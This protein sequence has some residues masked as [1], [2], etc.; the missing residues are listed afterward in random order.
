MLR[1]PINR[2][3]A[4]GAQRH[5][6]A[7]VNTTLLNKATAAG[8]GGGGAI[9]GMGNTRAAVQSSAA[10]TMNHSLARL[11]EVRHRLEDYVVWT[12]RA[13]DN[14]VGAEDDAFCGCSFVEFASEITGAANMG[15]L[16][17]QIDSLIVSENGIIEILEELM[18]KCELAFAATA[19]VP[20]LQPHRLPTS[21]SAEDFAASMMNHTAPMRDSKVRE[22]R[23]LLS[24]DRRQEIVLV[25]AKLIANIRK[26][27]QWKREDLENLA[28]LFD[29]FCTAQD[30]HHRLL[31]S[32]EE[33]LRNGWS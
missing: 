23:L 18:L 3:A 16:N 13:W 9:G 17:E 4:G 30:Q 15:I 20:Q 19:S 11:Q 29:S 22:L 32:I 28:A 14:L 2:T 25:A 31:I 33:T 5:L 6:P 27:S 24:I 7:V 10:L 8:G 1:D 12:Q 26:S 21:A